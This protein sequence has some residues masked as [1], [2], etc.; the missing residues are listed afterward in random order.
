METAFGGLG[1]GWY[2]LGLVRWSLGAGAVSDSSWVGKICQEAASLLCGA[3]Y[4]RPS[5]GV[6][7][8]P[9]APA[10]NSDGKG[11]EEKQEKIQDGP[12][13][14]GGAIPKKAIPD[15]IVIVPSPHLLTAQHLSCQASLVHF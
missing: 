9:D 13:S 2:K 14:F 15:D 6:L 12:N 1:R 10:Q 8:G 11:H 5:D 3:S 7:L 4:P